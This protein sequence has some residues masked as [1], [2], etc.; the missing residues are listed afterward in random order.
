[1]ALTGC[2]TNKPRDAKDC[3][4]FCVCSVLSSVSTLACCRA[5]LLVLSRS[6]EAHY[7]CNTVLMFVLYGLIRLWVHLVPVMKARD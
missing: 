3:G 5:V 4:T 1:M 6:L 7:E 2:G